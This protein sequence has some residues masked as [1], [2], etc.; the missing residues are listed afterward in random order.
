[1]TSGGAGVQDL[2]SADAAS[3]KALTVLFFRQLSAGLVDVA[4]SAPR[5]KCRRN[6]PAHFCGTSSN[7]IST[8]P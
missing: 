7:M 2:C 5:R 4:D 3:T 1:M 8:M 6:M